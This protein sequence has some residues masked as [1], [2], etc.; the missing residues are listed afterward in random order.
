MDYNEECVANYTRLTK[1]RVTDSHR[2]ESL[3]C[4]QVCRNSVLPTRD[5][6]IY[7]QQ[8]YRDF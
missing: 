2:D 8:I 4:C 6:T 3:L 7:V 1:E 5:N